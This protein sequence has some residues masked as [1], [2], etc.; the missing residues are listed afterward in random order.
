MPVTVP[1]TLSTVAMLEGVMLQVPPGKLSPGAGA[2]APWHSVLADIGD[3]D[4]LTVAVVMAKQPVVG[5]A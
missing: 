5:A 2:V 1:E 3:G 4:G